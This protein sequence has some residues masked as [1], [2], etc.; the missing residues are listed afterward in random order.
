MSTVNWEALVSYSWSDGLSG[1]INEGTLV[2][3]ANEGQKTYPL[4]YIHKPKYMG[5][6]DWARVREC[7]RLSVPVLRGKKG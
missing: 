3:W 6:E 2:L 4:A 7:I 1:H 5:A